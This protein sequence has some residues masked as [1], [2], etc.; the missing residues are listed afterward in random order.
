MDNNSISIIPLLRSLTRLDIAKN[1]ITSI[2]K[3]TFINSSLVELDL[4]ENSLSELSQG[5]LQVILE[6]GL[7]KVT[8]RI[9]S[10]P[11]SGQQTKY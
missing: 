6:F 10:Y 2:E 9:Y 8:S 1:H 4:S 5:S 7:T 3:Q 11:K